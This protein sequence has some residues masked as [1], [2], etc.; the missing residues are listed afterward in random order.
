MQSFELADFND[1]LRLARAQSEPQRLLFVFAQV[2]APSVG[3]VDGG[4]HLSPV[5]CVDKA[6]DDVVDF[7]QLVAESETVQKSWDMMFVG[8]L[9]G[10]G[11]NAPTL[12][13]ADDVLRQMV[14][15]IHAG[16]VSQYL[17]FDRRGEPVQLL[18]G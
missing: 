18:A 2:E 10:L 12:E 1:F 7:S 15:H 8:A 3:S 4:G 14:D 9:F 11:G 16:R 13:Q 17:V 6:P 5:L